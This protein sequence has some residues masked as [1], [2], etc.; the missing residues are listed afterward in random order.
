MWNSTFKDK[1]RKP[2]KRSG[3]KPKL[4][5]DRQTGVYGPFPKGAD[6]STWKPRK[7]TSFHTKPR[8]PMKK[9][10]SSP[11]ARA[12]RALWKIFSLFIKIRDGWRCFLCGTRA[13]GRKMHAGHFI[14]DAVGGVLLR[15]HEGNVHAECDDCNLHRADHR[16]A[17][18][19][20]MIATYGADFVAELRM[21]IHKTEHDFD[22][23]V[24]TEYYTQE[25][26]K[27]KLFGPLSFEES[28]GH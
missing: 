9:Q 4:I 5:G 28:I 11:A 3:F 7:L 27:M 13:Y 12:A 10:S 16:E 18:E 19:K 23:R 6:V 15:Y 2:L 26:E 24:K 17:Y 14:E 8:K 20:K 21:L 22:Y 1:P 25:V